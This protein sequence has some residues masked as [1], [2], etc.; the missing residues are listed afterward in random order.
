LLMFGVSAP[1]VLAIGV[2]LAIVGA[3]RLSLRDADFVGY[4]ALLIAG[5][6]TAIVLMRPA[7]IQHPGVLSRYMLPALPFALLFVA[8]GAVALVGRLRPA[9]AGA[10]AIGLAAL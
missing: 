4:V 10:I 8:E 9:A 7:W 1:M 2:A 6:A 3:W 5:S